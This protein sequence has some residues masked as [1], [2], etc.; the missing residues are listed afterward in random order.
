MMID[1]RCVEI[2]LVETEIRNLEIEFGDDNLSYDECLPIMEEKKKID[3]LMFRGEGLLGTQNQVDDLVTAEAVLETRFD[4]RS[5]QTST[6]MTANE[7]AKEENNFDA[8]LKWIEQSIY[9][10]DD[11]N[12]S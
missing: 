12:Y 4:E 8:D 7:A 3:E 11:G 5:I 2:G 1:E 9:D 6:L 10:D